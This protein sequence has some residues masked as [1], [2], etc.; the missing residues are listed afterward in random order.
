MHYSPKLVL[1][2]YRRIGISTCINEIRLTCSRG[3]FNK[4]TLPTQVYVQ[5]FIIIATLSFFVFL[6]WLAALPVSIV[7]RCL[8]GLLSWLLR[9]PA[10]QRRAVGDHGW[11]RG[12]RAADFDGQRHLPMLGLDR[13]CH[14]IFLRRPAVKQ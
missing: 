3:L 9:W 10:P 11:H 8:H 12:A 1:D 14:E 6:F 2:G 13:R 4:K 5:C 7:F